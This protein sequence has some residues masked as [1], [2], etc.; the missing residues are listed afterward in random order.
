MTHRTLISAAG[1]AA[2]LAAS[3][4]VADGAD[5]ATATQQVNAGSLSLSTARRA[6]SPSLPSPSTVP[7]R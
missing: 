7:T 6:T 1:I 5:A 3:L 4:L 2:A